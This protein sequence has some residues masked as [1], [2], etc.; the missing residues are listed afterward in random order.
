MNI[1]PLTIIVATLF[2]AALPAQAADAPP[3][4]QASAASG[5]NLSTLCDTCAV[6]DSVRT[7]TRKGKGSGVGVVG[8]AVVGGLLG[9]QVGGGTGKTLAT[10]GG[11]VAGGVAGNEIERRVKKYTVWVT[12]VTLK[13]GTQRSFEQRSAPAFKAGDVVHVEG[14]HLVRK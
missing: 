8:G 3:K 5:V 1:R 4:A 11:A 14:D 6:V 9:H 2:A 7:Q 13:N 10:V 12:H